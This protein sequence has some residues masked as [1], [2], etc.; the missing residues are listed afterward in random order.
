[1][2]PFNRF[3]RIIAVLI[4][5]LILYGCSRPAT[6]TNIH[7]RDLTG[8]EF[9]RDFSLNGTDGTR[10]TL[11]DFRDKVVLVFFGFTQCPDICP[12]ALLRAANV[13]KMLGE[14]GQRLQVLFITVDPERDKAQL[15]GNYVGAFDPT[16]LGLYGTLQ[17]TRKTAEEFKVYYKKIPTGSSYTM[18]HTALSYL[19][20]TAG[21]LR[22]ALSHTQTDEEYVQDIRKI[23]ALD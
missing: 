5:C 23:L 13:K 12:T 22:I 3:L 16:F 15:L 14:D 7:G 19:Y 1:M 2:L 11:S 17:E 18:D 20:D 9:G 8:A 6:L 4:G 21:R 10:H